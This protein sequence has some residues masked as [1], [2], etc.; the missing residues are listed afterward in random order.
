MA[1]DLTAEKEMTG[2][3]EKGRGRSIRN[4]GGN[5]TL[6]TDR[7]KCETTD[8]EKKKG[9]DSFLF[10]RNLAQPSRATKKERNNV[11]L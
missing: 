4:P 2:R 8:L 3:E 1:R 10:R 5:Q 7:K 6:S 11:G 9:K